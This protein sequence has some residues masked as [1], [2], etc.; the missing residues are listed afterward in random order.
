ML[1][2]DTCSGNYTCDLNTHTCNIPFEIQEENYLLCVLSSMDASQELYFRQQMNLT[3]I[4]DINAL[5]VASLAILRG[6]NK[7]CVGSIKN[8]CNKSNG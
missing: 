1:C 7:D 5:T 8:V 4:T 6:E 3:N 2:L